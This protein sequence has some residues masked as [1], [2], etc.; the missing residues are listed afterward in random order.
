MSADQSTA[1][2]PYWVNI[3]FFALTPL[4]AILGTLWLSTHN[5]VPATTWIFAF[6]ML[7]VCGLS[8]TAGY[9]RLYAHR[10]YQAAWPVRLFLVLFG[11]ATFQGSVLWWAAEHR[12]HH[13]FEDT[14][15]D[16][17]WIGR[18]FWFAHIGWLLEKRNDASMDNVKELLSDPMLHW[19]QRL[20]LP[21]AILM[22]F[23]FPMAVGALWGDPWGGLIIAG[24]VRMVVNHHTTF[25]I[26]SFCHRIGKKT[27][28]RDLTASDSWITALMTYGEGY[29]NFHHHFNSD[30]R[31]G[32]RLYHFDPTKWLIVMMQTLGL[33]WGLRCAN[34]WNILQARLL[35]DQQ[36][37]HQRLASCSEAVHDRINEL[38]GSALEQLQQAFERV[39][40]LKADY[41]R[42]R[43]DHLTTMKAQLRHLRREIRHARQEFKAAW[44]E[45]QLINKDPIAAVG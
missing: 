19:Q 40:R 39:T 37:T 13:R 15:R 32:I 10:S 12:V 45:W 25:S 43:H 16:P 30:Y 35:A 44:Q 33:V 21:I 11:S 22:G 5:G 8:I 42:I 2:K 23:G 26:N 3:I 31:N 6:I 18:G 27:Y 20:Y 9:H 1:S 14:A 17:Y 41:R 38:L 34:K 36:R 29:H 7:G 4:G 24:L 28:D